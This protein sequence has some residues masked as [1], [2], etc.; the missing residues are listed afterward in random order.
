[1]AR[2]SSLWRLA[3]SASARRLLASQQLGT[4]LLGALAFRDVHDGAQNPGALVRL[5]GVEP[6]LDRDFAPV[7]PQ[8]VEVPPGA[9][10]AHLRLM[11]EVIA[12]LWVPDPEPM[13]NE[14]FHGLSYQ[15]IAAVAEQFLRL[16]IGED[17]LVFLVHHNHRVRSRLDRNTK[18]PLG[19]LALRDVAST[20]G[21]PSAEG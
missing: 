1:M 2:N 7:F 11:Q 4:F 6:D 8:A 21:E 9:R 19:L 16:R 15:F 10:R 14:G 3:R 13:G 5:N 12:V 20:D 17:D 18:H